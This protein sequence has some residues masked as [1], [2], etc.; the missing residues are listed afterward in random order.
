MRQALVTDEP[1]LPEPATDGELMARAAA[2][3]RDAFADL[4][5][6]HERSLRGYLGRLCG[7]A[8]RAEELA[9]EAFVRLYQAA[10][11]YRDQGRLL[12]YLFRIAINLLRSEERRHR[13]W[14]LLVPLYA[15]GRD[16]RAPGGADE[17]LLR[18]ELQK[19][20]RAELQ[21]LPLLF[22]VPLLL[23]EVE[24]WSYDDIARLLGC[25]EGTVKSR[26]HR[27][28][29]RLRR[30]LASYLHEGAP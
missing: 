19:R 22:R 18:G 21:R 12:P 23:Y 3:D 26:L 30:A 2:G 8:E 24:E 15:G 28:R 6:R 7:S 27:G 25:R 14:R 20:V 11:G 13:R 29:A 16:E 1:S 4:V 5:T 10:A 9:Q 17:A